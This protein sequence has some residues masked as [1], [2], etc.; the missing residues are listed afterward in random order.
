MAWQAAAPNM[1]HI[2]SPSVNL[3]TLTGRRGSDQY[4]CR[5]YKFMNI[6]PAAAAAGTPPAPG[7]A[8]P[9][10]Q[11]NA[12]APPVAAPP[13]AQPTPASR[14]APSNKASRK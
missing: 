9:P 4:T 6:A 12:A 11:N 1:G 13:P 3:A 7:D 10:A 8:V 2:Q 14:P 5:R